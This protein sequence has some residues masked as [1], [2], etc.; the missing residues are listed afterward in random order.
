MCQAAK[1]CCQGARGEMVAL[2][3]SAA[4]EG[5]R[6]V[7]S[8]DCCDMR[9]AVKAWLPRQCKPCACCSV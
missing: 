8:L 6:E 3:M 5:F 4:R 9:H 1:K 2:R 7:P